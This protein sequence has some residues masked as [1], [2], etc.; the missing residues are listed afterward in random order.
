MLSRA[1]LRYSGV[2]GAMGANIAVVT[3]LSAIPIAMTVAMMSE[4]IAVNSER[5]LMQSA[6]DAAALSGAQNLMMVGSGARQ[7]TVDVERFALLQVGTFAGRATVSFK[8]T[9]GPDG[10]YVVD[11]IATRPSFFGNLVP[12]GGFRIEVKSVAESM[13]VQP[14]CIIGDYSVSGGSAITAADQSSI[15][16]KNCIV[17]S[18]SDFVLNSLATVE[19]GAPRA[20]GIATGTGFS[21]AAQS[22]AL[23]ISEPFKGRSITPAVACASVP[24]GGRFEHS[25]GTRVLAPGVHRIDFEIEGTGILRLQPGEHVFCNGL[26]IEGNGRLLGDD[27]L[28]MFTKGS[29]LS[30]SDN[31]FVS[32]SG[33]RSGN[34]AGFVMVSTRDNN[35]NFYIGSSN[36][37]KLLG[38]IYLPLARL[39]VSTSG[40]VAE[41]SQWS[42]IVAKEIAL[43]NKARLT[44]NSD[45]VGS[46]V[47][48]PI[49]VGNQTGA[50][51]VPLRL[52][53]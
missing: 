16:A 48:V 33:R 9:P 47:P 28:L 39:S 4:V 36:V 5:A 49:G 23:K 7:S 40:E 50:A 10:S 52:K 25:T 37:D 46:P 11:G 26:E 51:G 17:H 44:I 32:L 34:W 2:T 12:P 20:T 18:N 13:Q 21:P 24:D 42:V 41:S 53:N 29:S 30:V 27:V 45:Y 22:G 19:A 1:L 35:K 15:R 38:T 14:L 31:A 3:A 8:A 43:M 6:A